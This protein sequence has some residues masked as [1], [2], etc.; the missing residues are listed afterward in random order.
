MTSISITQKNPTLLILTIQM[1]TDVNI[2]KNIILM[3]K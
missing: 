2:L 3:M 1:S